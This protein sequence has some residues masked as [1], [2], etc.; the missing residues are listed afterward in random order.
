LKP[1]SKA[2]AEGSSRL[3]GSKESSQ[4][5]LVTSLDKKQTE[6]PDQKT[7][8]VIIYYLPTLIL[9]VGGMVLW[10]WKKRKTNDQTI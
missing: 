1:K 9:I 6:A 3:T 4:V 2:K 8:P 10:I 5:G 7:L